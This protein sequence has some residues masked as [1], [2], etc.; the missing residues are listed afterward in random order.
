MSIVFINGKFIPEEQACISVLDRGFIFGDG[1]YEL[2]PVYGG[3]PFRLNE[4]L[5]RLHNN[6]DAIRLKSPYTYQEWENILTELISKASDTELALYLHVTRG[7]AKRDHAI[8]AEITPTVFAM[9]NP[10]KPPTKE[11]MS[12]GIAAITCDDF[13]WRNCH[14]KAIS[15]LSNV[16]LRQMAVDANAVEA[17]LVRNGEVTEG[18]ASNLFIVKDGTLITPPKGP[19]LLPGITRDL[20]LEIAEQNAIPY[21]EAII[22]D[23][24][25]KSADEIWITSSMKEI[26]PVTLLNNTPVGNGKP[27]PMWSKMI[28]LFQEFKNSLRA[29]A[30]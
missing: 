3:K 4:H 7:V 14:I 10:L 19:Y 30:N 18:A 23:Q 12:E 24:Q 26:A 16:L 15:L 28:D 21:S 27:G 1:V 8:P 5:D 9:A 6:F 20:I 13:R 25:L 11:Q 22:T 2:I 29:K 17:I